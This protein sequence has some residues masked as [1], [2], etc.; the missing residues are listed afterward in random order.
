MLI[1]NESFNP[2]PITKLVVL[3]ALGMS[4]LSPMSCNFQCF[5]CFKRIHKARIE[6]FSHLFHF[7]KHKLY[8]QFKIEQLRIEYVFHFDSNRKI[9]L[10]TFYGGK[11]SHSHQ[12]CRQ[13]IDLYG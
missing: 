6:N 7:D 2:T 3:V 8:I 13:H 12:R 5:L 11:V 9:F 1:K 10:L 4:I